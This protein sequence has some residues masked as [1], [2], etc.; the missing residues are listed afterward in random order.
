[1]TV[2]VLPPNLVNQIAAGE[3][4]ERPAS[5]VKELVE[6]A[7]DAGAR[8]VD[9]TMND[10]GRSLIVVS[11]DGRGM[12]ERELHLAVERHATSKLPDDDLTEIGFFGFRGEALPSI[13][14]VARL[15]I[16]S[17]PPGA[18]SA[19]YIRVEGGRREGP[20]GKWRGPQC[21]RQGA[22]DAT[23]SCGQ[24]RLSG[25]GQGAARTRR[26]SDNRKAHTPLHRAAI[27]G[28]AAIVPILLKHGASTEARDKEGRTPIEY[29]RNKE[30][31][32]HLGERRA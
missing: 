7:L 12:D 21:D 25:C 13:G 32:R 6:N 18:S 4:V 28:K 27:R 3:V 30:I 17:R 19:W 1:M 8:H 22:G 5:V 11:D 16:T 23:L 9:V 20:A 24:P 14:A 29:A 15:T 10:G 2:R 31:R 26:G